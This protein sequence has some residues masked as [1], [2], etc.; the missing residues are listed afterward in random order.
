M[1]SEAQLR[2]QLT[3][4]LGML[5]KGINSNRNRTPAGESYW[6]ERIR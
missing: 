4:N 5:E 1:I 6:S 2:D 3:V